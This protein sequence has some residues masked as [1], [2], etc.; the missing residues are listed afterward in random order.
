MLTLLLILSSD[1]CW[2][3]LPRPLSSKNLKINIDFSRCTFLFF[4]FWCTQSN[5]PQL[6]L[7]SEYRALYIGIPFYDLDIGLTYNCNNWD[8]NPGIALSFIFENS[9]PSMNAHNSISVLY[10][11]LSI[12]QKYKNNLIIQTNFSQKYSGLKK[13]Q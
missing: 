10:R 5:F 3:I 11:A 6:A 7:F 4:G 2:C 1:L 8:K 12:N 13:V 9:I